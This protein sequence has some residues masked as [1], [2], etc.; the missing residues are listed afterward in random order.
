MIIIDNFLTQD[1]L[2]LI[3]DNIF[4]ESFT[5]TF[6]PGVAI[7]PDEH[8][9]LYHK[10]YHYNDGSERYNPQKIYSEFYFILEP[11]IS[12]LL[13]KESEFKQILRIKAN[14]YPQTSEI[15]RHN[16]HTDFGFPCKGLLFY[17]NNNNGYTEFANGQC[18]RS[19]ENRA[20]FFDPSIPHRSTS[21]TNQKIR[22]S[23][24]INYQ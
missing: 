5:W 12:N 21:C 17:V 19:I 11:I 1:Q 13:A 7:I 16:Y 10:F 24:N 22:V 3:K 8:Y 6:A 9:H 4:S 18:V 20:L 14:G 2:S 23:I 15:V